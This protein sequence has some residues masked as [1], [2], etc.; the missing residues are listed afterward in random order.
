MMFFLF[1]FLLFSSFDEANDFYKNGKYE[2]ALEKYL[3]I[4]SDVIDLNLNYNI[5][6]TYYRLGKL[7]MAKAYYLKVL[8]Y[9]SRDSDSLYNLQLINSKLNQPQ[10]SNIN[11]I[12]SFFDLNE[13]AIINFFL[14]FVTLILI[15]LFIKKIKEKKSILLISFMTI[16]VILVYAFILVLTA[17]NYKDFKTEK[18]VIIEASKLLSAPSSSSVDLTIL[19]EGTLLEKLFCEDTWCKVILEDKYIGWVDKEKLMEI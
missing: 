7:G 12:L 16:N 3:D 5:A 13:L 4:K 1:S 2:K 11:K 10:L 14:F 8:K 17:F 19:N 9:K 15:F 18:I 6:N